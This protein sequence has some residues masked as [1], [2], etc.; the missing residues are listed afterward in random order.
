M[1]SGFETQKSIKRPNK[2]N[3]T[4]LS[5]EAE[6][7]SDKIQY[8]CTINSNHLSANWDERFLSL[9]K[10]VD[11]ATTP[12][13]GE[14][15]SSQL[16]TDPCLEELGQGGKG[17]T[18][19]RRPDGYQCQAG[20]AGRQA[21]RPAQSH[22]RVSFPGQGPQPWS[23]PCSPGPSAEPRSGP[24]WAC[25]CL[26]P[27]EAGSEG[28]APPCEAPKSRFSQG[29]CWPTTACQQ[30]PGRSVT[31]STGPPDCHADLWR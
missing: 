22:T 19:Q 5:T 30:L 11:T 27:S 9:T 23:H 13:W 2:R 3:H 31:M 20:E 12:Q 15:H 28:A 6:K 18:V 17:Q 29:D 4:I 8:L 24:G 14:P 26:R 21:P 1:H 25:R 10:G 16:G 7:T